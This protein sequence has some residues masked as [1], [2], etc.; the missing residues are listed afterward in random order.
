MR[1]GKKEKLNFYNVRSPGAVLIRRRRMNRVIDNVKLMF[2]RRGYINR[3]DDDEKEKKI[4]PHAD[5]RY[6]LN[7]RDGDANVVAYFVKGAKI[8]IDV[9]KNVITKIDENVKH[10]FLIYDKCLTPDAKSAVSINKIFV[11][12]LF[13]FDEM[14]YDVISLSRSRYSKFDKSSETIF[15]EWNKL[16]IVLSTDPICKYYGFKS[17]NIILIKDE[18]DEGEVSLRRCV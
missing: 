11:F 10:V 18:E 1:E 12:E 16:P 5:I 3:D 4:Y 17:G 6:A 2:N 7:Y 14:S 9:I 8:S 15:K 13:S